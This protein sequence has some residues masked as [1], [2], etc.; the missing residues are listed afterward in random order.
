MRK[1]CN[2]KQRLSLLMMTI[3]Q[4]DT[5]PQYDVE[6]DYDNAKKRRVLSTM[7]A[8][9]RAKTPSPDQSPR[10]IFYIFTLKTPDFYHTMSL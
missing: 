2:T 4:Y 5:M 7:P 6:V 10:T 8:Q 9:T 1:L 3:P